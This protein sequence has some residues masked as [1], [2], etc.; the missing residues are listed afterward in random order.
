MSKKTAVILVIIFFLGVLV[1]AAAIID[2]YSER[3]NLG[4]YPHSNDAGIYYKTLDANIS[5]AYF[6]PYDIVVRF[7]NRPFILDRSENLFSNIWNDSKKVINDRLIEGL[8]ESTEEWDELCDNPGVTVAMGGYFPIEYLG[9]MLGVEEPEIS[10]ITVDKVMIIPREAGMDVYFHT[11]EMVYESTGLQ[12]Y[13]LF[14]NEN[15][16]NITELLSKNPNYSNSY[17]TDLY[18]IVKE[19]VWKNYY[20]PDIPVSSDLSSHNI[21][22]IFAGLP[23]IINDY[24][25]AA[26]NLGSNGET[27]LMK[28]TASLIKDD[29]LVKSNNLFTTHF[30]SY[31]NLFFTNQF[32]LYGIGNDGWVTYRYTPG[33]EGDEKG[34]IG[35]AFINAYETLNTISGLSS[36]LGGE[37]FLS[38]IEE[39]ENFY[40]FSF[41]Y[42]Y[43]SKI[44]AIK[45]E[46][47]AAVIMTTATRTIE[48]RMLPLDFKKMSE[49]TQVEIPYIFNFSN[50]QW[51]NGLT[52]LNTSEAYNIYIGYGTFSG[53]Q[54]LMEP[55]W[56]FEKKSG[57]KETYILQRGNE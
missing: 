19:N 55:V 57:Q 45:D 35:N 50:N 52:D 24:V 11:D 44:I 7:N 41:D 16:H 30:D 53:N 8:S 15:F 34:L 4:F 56:I 10:N 21:P 22:W 17:Y 37:L 51:L 27:A 46:T 5:E 13:G 42:R 25:E 18:K 26:A 38:R 6:N 36:D 14:T 49:D 39:T 12:P 20:E 1:Q 3:F 28:Q 32:N 33:T 43:D 31:G 40:T 47:H 2:Y 9:F 23:A 54:N 48:A 29:L